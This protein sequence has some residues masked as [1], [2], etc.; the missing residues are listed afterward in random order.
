MTSLWYNTA[1]HNVKP[2]QSK[3]GKML[4]FLVFLC[5]FCGILAVLSHFPAI[6]KMT[7]QFVKVI[8]MMTSTSRAG[9]CS[10]GITS[11]A[12]AP[13]SGI[14][15][16]IPVGARPCYTPPAAPTFY[17]TYHS[18]SKMF[19]NGRKSTTSYRNPT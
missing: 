17:D 3:G 4:T 2:T 11:W 8:D 6:S 10:R 13:T 15:F 7:L 16:C 1:C 5:L 12:D 18:Y 9:R 14:R 19:T